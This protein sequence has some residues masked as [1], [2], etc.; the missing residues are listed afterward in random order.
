VV[1][2]PFT[3]DSRGF[4]FVTM[5]TDKDAKMAIQSINKYVIDGKELNVEI[6]KRNR[7]HHST[8]GVYLGPSSTSI[9]RR[10]PFSPK[11]RYTKRS[12]SRSRSYHKERNYR[13]PK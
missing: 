3:K 5:E 10:T 13:K 7:P 11:R 4:G 9:T 2:D 8:P 12:R 1:R 6:S